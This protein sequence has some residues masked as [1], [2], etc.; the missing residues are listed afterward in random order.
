MMAKIGEVIVGPI[1][2]GLVI[3]SV[4]GGLTYQYV[5]SIKAF[6]LKD[7]LF[8]IAVGISVTI[9]RYRMKRIIEHDPKQRLM[10]KS[11]PGMT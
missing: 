6:T 3:A 9:H 1:G 5:G 8:V 4:A 11:L 7:V 10:E 2:Q